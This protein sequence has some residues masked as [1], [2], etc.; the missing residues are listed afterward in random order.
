MDFSR[1][2][3]SRR[4]RD[5]ALGM[6]PTSTYS[7]ATFDLI[8]DM[9]TLGRSDK[10]APSRRRQNTLRDFKSR[11]I[12]GSTFLRILFTQ[13][14]LREGNSFDHGMFEVCEL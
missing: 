4:L 7:F 13:E 3:F 14:F 11:S 5:G 8:L 1:P 12:L 9:R 2:S 6:S 10:A